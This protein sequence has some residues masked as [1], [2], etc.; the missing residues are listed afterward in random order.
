MIDNT[1]RHRA[2]DGMTQAQDDEQ[3]QRQGPSPCD[4]QPGNYIA[5]REASYAS[6][7]ASALQRS[8]A[9]AS[10]A[11]FSDNGLVVTVRART[12]AGWLSCVYLRPRT[13]RSDANARA[14]SR[15]AEAE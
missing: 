9:D 1:I 11:L 4:F 13:L 3:A 12:L 5:Q 15:R 7:G 6:L 10:L 8:K 2:R 14:A